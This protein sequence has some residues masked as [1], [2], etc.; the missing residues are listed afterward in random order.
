MN[1]ADRSLALVDMAFRR[2]FAFFDLEPTLNSAWKKY[3]VNEMN[4]DKSIAE[5]I[6]LSIGNLNNEISNDSRLGNN[7]KSD[8]A[9]L[10]QQKVLKIKILKVG[11][12]K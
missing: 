8:I 2:R 11:L 3:V 6:R 10:L 5:K 9:S 12:M 7:F 4:M 1:L